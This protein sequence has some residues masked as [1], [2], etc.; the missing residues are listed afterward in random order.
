M[1]NEDL[2]PAI[3]ES[4]EFLGLIFAN[5]SKLLTVIEEYMKKENFVSFYGATSVWD[6]SWAY[7]GFY[8][9][10]PHYLCRVYV[11]KEGSGKKPNTRDKIFQFVNIYFMPENVL[12][13][14]VVFGITKL[15]REEFDNNWST[16]MLLNSGPN[17]INSERVES[18][19][20]C[21]GDAES[22][23]EVIHYKVIPLVEFKDQPT[24]ESMCKE[25]VSKFRE[26]KVN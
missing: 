14:V 16:L 24:A 3:K 22:A 26:I 15:R 12:E 8:G 19:E 5:T 1:K 21:Y 6:R 9:W 20:A 25:L 17:F 7:Y 18:W 11:P 10:L 2:G 13:P 4:F 23:I